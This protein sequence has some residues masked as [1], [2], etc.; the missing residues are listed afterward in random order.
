[1]PLQ[2]APRI[3]AE[4]GWSPTRSR[5]PHLVTMA[6]ALAAHHLLLLLLLFCC[7]LL[8]A[9]AAPVA[10]GQQ[11]VPTCAHPY[12]RVKSSR[13]TVIPGASVILAAKLANKG[14]R[15]L[16]G[17]NVR[18]DL[19]PGL[20]ATGQQFKAPPLIVDGGATASAYWM[21][22]TL[23]PGKRHGRVLKLRAQACATATPGSYPIGGAVYLTNATKAVTCLSSGV[24]KPPVVRRGSR[25]D[26]GIYYYNLCSLAHCTIVTYR[27]ASRSGVRDGGPPM[28]RLPAPHRLQRR[29]VAALL[30]TLCTLRATSWLMVN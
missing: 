21:D 27:F 2:G 18:L 4:A 23:K 3:I 17:V 20:V 9:H 16:S 15:T 7:T 29:P 25:A 13:T 12:L 8:M 5:R 22:L 19:P 14:S 28:K 1:M 26:L 10:S 30:A 24:A 11:R 6:A